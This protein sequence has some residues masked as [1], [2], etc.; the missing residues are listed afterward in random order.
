[1][2]AAEECDET[3]DELAARFE[4]EVIALLATLFDAAMR[5]TLQSTDAEYP[6]TETMVRAYAGF[7]SFQQGTNLTAWLFRIQSN[8]HINNS[9]KRTRRPT[10]TLTDTIHDWQLAANAERSPRALRSAEVEVLES[11]PDNDI[12]K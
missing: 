8:T 9:R 3:D 11:L 1:M 7:R 4:C 2:S 12:R 10:E 6:L 5:M